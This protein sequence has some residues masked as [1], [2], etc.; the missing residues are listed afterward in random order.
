[1]RG[2]A[3]GLMWVVDGV[4]VCVLTERDYNIPKGG[5]C[6]VGAMNKASSTVAG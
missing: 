3:E 2:L 4:Y 1:M 6:K 5:G